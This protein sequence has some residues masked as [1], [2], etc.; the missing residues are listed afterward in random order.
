MSMGRYMRAWDRSNVQP[1]MYGAQTVS[2]ARDDL[3][4]KATGISPSTAA[5]V[6]S[7]K[8][9]YHATFLGHYGAVGTPMTTLGTHGALSYGSPG[10]RLALADQPQEDAC[11]PGDIQCYM[12]KGMKPGGF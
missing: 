7:T 5:A 1:I 9:P 10:Q 8:V 3:R 12:R 11:A 2:A 4:G 6:G